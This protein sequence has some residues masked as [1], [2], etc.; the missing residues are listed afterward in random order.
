MST[1]KITPPPPRGGPVLEVDKDGNISEQ[2]P[3]QLIWQRW[4]GNLATNL[5]PGVSGTVTLVKLTGGGSNGSLT[6][7]NGVITAFTAPT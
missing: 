5:S 1:P 3:F 2:S 6:F 4:F 7:V